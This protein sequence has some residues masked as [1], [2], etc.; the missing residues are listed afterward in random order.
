MKKSNFGCR[1]I[2]R[3]TVFSILKIEAN[4]KRGFFGSQYTTKHLGTLNQKPIGRLSSMSTWLE[5]RHTRTQSG[6]F[7][8]HLA[9]IQRCYLE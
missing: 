2:G 7:S 8:H 6:I 1:S 5:Y 9:K 3:G 4:I